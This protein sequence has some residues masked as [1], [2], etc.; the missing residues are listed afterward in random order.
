[1]TNLDTKLATEM[2]ALKEKITAMQA[3]LVT[4]NHVEDLKR[5]IEDSKRVLRAPPT[6]LIPH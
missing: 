6:S 2:A 4:Y 1:M 5:D 3:E